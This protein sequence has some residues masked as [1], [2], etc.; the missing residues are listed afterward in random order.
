MANSKLTVIGETGRDVGET[1]DN[2]R[3]AEHV[4]S[5]IT[6]VVRSNYISG[7]SNYFAEDARGRQ[8]DKAAVCREERCESQKNARQI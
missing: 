8:I 5:A 3:I 4:F 7:K 1:I 6:I 2:D